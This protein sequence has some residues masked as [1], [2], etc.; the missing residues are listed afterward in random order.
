[1][2]KFVVRR[3]LWTIPIIL[4]VIF[5]TFWM[6]RAIK[7]SPFRKSERAVPP[8]VLAN[9]NR[10]F[11]L[12]KPWYVQYKRY[13]VDVAKADLGPSLVLRNQSVHA[14]DEHHFPLSAELGGLAM[15][16]SMVVG[17]PLGIVSALRVNTLTDYI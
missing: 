10:K 6:M 9:L 15:L 13:V 5:M 7:G 12:S 14:I 4:L 2:L 16:L 11:G 17:I 3:V 1:M 8:G